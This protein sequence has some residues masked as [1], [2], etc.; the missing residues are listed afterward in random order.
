MARLT[1]ADEGDRLA[2]GIVNNALTSAAGTVLTVYTD[3]AGTVLADIQTLLGATIPGSVLTVDSDSLIPQFLGPAGDVTTLYIA[4]AGHPTPV[5]IYAQPLISAP[6]GGGTGS[7]TNAYA[8]IVVAAGVYTARKVLDGSVISSGS[9]FKTVLQATITAVQA[10]GGGRILIGHGTYQL[11][12]S[13]VSIPNP[14]QVQIIGSGGYAM[15]RQASNVGVGTIIQAIGTW[16][17]GTSMITIGASGVSGNAPACVIADMHFDGAGKDIHVVHGFN[18]QDLKIQRYSMNNVSV[19]NQRALIW[20]ESD[21]A[22]NSGSGANAEIMDG[23]MRNAYRAIHVIGT[24]A[25]SGRIMNIDAWTCTRHIELHQGGWHVALCHLVGNTSTD[26][27]LFTDSGPTIAV[28]NY[29]D[30]V[31]AGGW[32]VEVASGGVKSKYNNNHFIT[33]GDATT[34]GIKFTAQR[35]QVM[36]NT[37]TT[38]GGAFLKFTSAGNGGEIIGNVGDGPTAGHTIEDSTGAAR[39]DANG[40]GFYYLGNLII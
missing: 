15:N 21:Q 18:A 25:N 17:A 39:P 37:F 29:F 1:F 10:V 19:A 22:E 26:F 35:N 27:N 31:K 24:G 6:A 30:S 8:S 32:C 5:P 7:L 20:L 23:W 11:D 40:A 2:F 4:S 38:S 36:G 34:L 14:G 16:T 28:D 9:D 13:G 33:S 12:G 3:P